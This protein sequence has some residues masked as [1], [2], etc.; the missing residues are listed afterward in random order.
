[1]DSMVPVQGGLN[2]QNCPEEQ[3]AEEEADE[4]EC[5][6][7]TTN[8]ETR[9]QPAT[10][11]EEEVEERRT[12]EDEAAIQDSRIP[13]FEDEDCKN[14][15]T[16]FQEVEQHRATD[17]ATL[18]RSH[19]RSKTISR[20]IVPMMRKMFERAKSCDPDVI[21][22]HGDGTESSRSSFSQYQLTPSG[23]PHAHSVSP[24]PSSLTI[25]ECGSSPSMPRA[26]SK[27]AGSTGLITKIKAKFK[28]SS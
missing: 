16:H 15:E 18:G 25:S 5:Q 6:G 22:P 28:S 21:S 7:L 19:S 4:E 17:S 10:P 3:L 1:M 2:Q 11:E 12:C 27:G 13:R 8:P 23:L 20:S 14:E 9:L 26:R 24:A